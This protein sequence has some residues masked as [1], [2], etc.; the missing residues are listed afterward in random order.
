[1]ATRTSAS[2][3]QVRRTTF[4]GRRA[5]QLESDSMRVTVL[6]GG[7]HIAEL[8]HKQAKVNPLWDS[9]WKN[10]EPWQCTPRMTKYGEGPEA[11]LLAGLTG[12][13]FCCD[14]FG[15][16]S[17]AEAAAGHNVHGETGVTRWKVTNTVKSVRQAK[18]TIANDL[19]ISGL[20]VQRTLTLRAGET[21]VEVDVRIKNNDKMDKPLTFNEHVTLGPP[22]LEKG[23]TLFDLPADRSM[24][25]DLE[26]GGPNRL[27]R[28]KSFTWPKA[29]P[30][31]GRAMVDMR[32]VPKDRRSSDFSTHRM[33][34]KK[35]FG[36]FT[37]INPRLGCLA[38]YVFPRAVCPWMGM[39][40]ENYGRTTAP[41]NGKALTR[42]ME[43][44]NTPWPLPKRDNVDLNRLF[45]QPTYAW[46][47]AKGEIRY[48]FA[49]FLSPVPDD[50]SAVTDVTVADSQIVLQGTR[51]AQTLSLPFRGSVQ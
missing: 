28:G 16:P 43:F 39:W 17:D 25:A 24:T 50:C 21:A 40:E 31:K 22:F 23:V 26:M 29:P 46:I 27:A 35:P 12:H 1:M 44:G 4:N 51:A 32:I 6:L 11:K 49:A 48:R 19:A 14:F 15:P 36:W 47:D 3:V 8:Y 2:A 18:V 10:I 34:P 13:N 7:G 9:P 30:A 37:A 20:T 33:N 42:G 38:G 5:V 45:G 41:W